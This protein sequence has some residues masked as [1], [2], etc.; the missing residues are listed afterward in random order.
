MSTVFRARQGRD[1]NFWPVTYHVPQLPLND[2]QQKVSED[3]FGVACTADGWLGVVEDIKDFNAR[4]KYSGVTWTLGYAFRSGRR[5]LKS[6]WSWIL[7]DGTL[8]R[9]LPGGS[10]RIFFKEVC[11]ELLDAH[12]EPERFGIRVEPS[13][14]ADR[15][16]EKKS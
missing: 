4:R 9:D 7:P 8:Q 6:T 3:L 2:L 14:F 1:P 15:L 13:D 10:E 11:Q 5:G 12:Q 16:L